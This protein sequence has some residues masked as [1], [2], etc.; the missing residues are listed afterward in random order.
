MC[1]QSRAS[2]RTS[3]KRG[4]AVAANCDVC[5]RVYQMKRLSVNDAMQSTLPR[6]PLIASS[7]E[8]TRKAAAMHRYVDV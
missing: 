5:S 4:A 1:M 2:S 7:V 3:M 8:S 6:D